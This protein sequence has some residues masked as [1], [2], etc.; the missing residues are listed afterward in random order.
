M[1]DQIPNVDRDPSTG[2]EIL[3]A[4]IGLPTVLNGPIRVVEYAPAWPSLFEREAG[5]I[6]RALGGRTRRVWTYDQ[7]DADSKTVVETIIRRARAV[8]AEQEHAPRGLT[9]HAR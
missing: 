4:R 9:A 3:A 1:A 2:E 8:R 7:N 5:R 6:R